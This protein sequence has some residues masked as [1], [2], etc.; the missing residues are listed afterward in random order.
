VPPGSQRHH[1]IPNFYTEEKPSSESGHQR[2]HEAFQTVRKLFQVL[3]RRPFAAA[4]ARRTEPVPSRQR[5]TLGSIAVSTQ[6]ATW[7]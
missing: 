4:P 1:F 5:V 6:T 7:R 2:P 3:G